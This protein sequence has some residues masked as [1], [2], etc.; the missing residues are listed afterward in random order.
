MWG[1]LSAIYY[2]GNKDVA[3][4]GQS[5][6]A[7]SSNIQHRYIVVIVSSRQAVYSKEHVNSQSILFCPSS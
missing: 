5:F 1:P 4:R 7:L 6:V 3:C 2:L